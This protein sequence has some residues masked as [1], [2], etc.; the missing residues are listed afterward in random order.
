MRP[1]SSSQV[2]N[3]YPDLSPRSK[4][5]PSACHFLGLGA[6]FDFGRGVVRDPLV[7]VSSVAQHAVR[8]KPCVWLKLCFENGK[9]TADL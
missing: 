3:P 5:D 1:H 8:W 6:E 4:G 2:A 7:Y 9:C